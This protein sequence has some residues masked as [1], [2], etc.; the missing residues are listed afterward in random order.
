MSLDLGQIVTQIIAFLVM[1]WILKRY[2]WKP[3]LSLLHEREDK[4]RLEFD[5]IAAKQNESQELVD[6][7]E[8]KLKEIHAESR[9]IIRDAATQGRK[10]AAE[11]QEQAQA[12]AREI[13]EQAKTD[14]KREID[15]AYIHLRKDMVEMVVKVS[16]KLMGQKLD[17][18][19]NKKLIADFVE[20]PRIK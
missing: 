18:E 13:V 7:Y 19:S 17:D 14:V 8:A 6:K 20:E 4:I 10:V 16:E 2:G 1:L 9:R 3:I 5:K 15:E 12:Q 11:I